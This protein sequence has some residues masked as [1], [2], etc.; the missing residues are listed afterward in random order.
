MEQR[1][2]PAFLLAAAALAVGM[3]A[4][5]SATT[6]DSG[7][8]FQTQAGKA[9][10]YVN[11]DEAG[12]S[13]AF[14]NTPIDNGVRTNGV[15]LGADGSVEYLVGDLGDLPEPTLE[16]STFSAA[17]WTIDAAADGTRF[18]NDATGHGMF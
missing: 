9:I 4:T 17:G 5:A 12:C 2:A 7:V 6:A 13:A 15:R 14:T 16:Y 3:P 10:C 11:V 8:E 18:T 1:L